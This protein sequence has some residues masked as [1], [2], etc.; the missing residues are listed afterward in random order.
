MRCQRLNRRVIIAVLAVIVAAVLLWLWLWL[1][2]STPPR[3][4]VDFLDVG[5][6]DAELLR[7]GRTEMLVDGGPDFTVLSGLGESLPVLDRHLETVILTHPHADHLVGL[8][9]VL[10]Q[11]DVDALYYTGAGT[12]PEWSALVAAAKA[13][14]V[15]MRRLSAGMTL[16]LEDQTITVLWPPAGYQPPQGDE[17]YRSAVLCVRPTAAVSATPSSPCEILLM[18]DAPSDV[19]AQLLKANAVPRAQVLKVGHHGSRT[20]SSSAFLTAA[21]PAIAVIEVGKNSYGHPAWVTLA[22]LKQAGARLLTTITDG[23]VRLT[24]GADGPPHATTGLLAAWPPLR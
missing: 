23:H 3:L 10:N 1:W 4:T 8:I 21:H 12:L 24:F 7:V 9:H 13:R 17:N 19:E 16:P 11:Y 15:P 18:G 22:R 6:G 2:L 14:G 5:Q 20:S